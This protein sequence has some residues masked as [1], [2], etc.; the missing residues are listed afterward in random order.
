MVCDARIHHRRSHSNHQSC[1]AVKQGRCTPRRRDGSRH[2]KI[3]VKATAPNLLTANKKQRISQAAQSP[4]CCK[5]LLATVEN[6]SGSVMLLD[7][8]LFT[9]DGP[10]GVVEGQRRDKQRKTLADECEV[11]DRP[12]NERPPIECTDTGKDCAAASRRVS[13]TTGIGVP[14][15]SET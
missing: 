9:L 6:W 3:I 7:M 8:T 14:A 12:P 10:S 4:P 5:Q 1:L 2:S 11:V 15:C 13:L